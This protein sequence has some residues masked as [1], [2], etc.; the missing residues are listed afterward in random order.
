MWSVRRERTRCG[1]PRGTWRRSCPGSC[2]CTGVGGLVCWFPAATPAP[3]TAGYRVWIHSI[4]NTVFCWFKVKYWRFGLVGRANPMHRWVADPRNKA[5]SVS[6]YILIYAMLVISPLLKW[7]PRS[8]SGWLHGPE[9]CTSLPRSS[10]WSGGSGQWSDLAAARH[11]GNGYAMQYNTQIKKG[12]WNNDTWDEPQRTLVLMFSVPERVSVWAASRSGSMEGRGWSRHSFYT[13]LWSACL[14]GH[15]GKHSTSFSRGILQRL[16][17]Y[18]PITCIKNEEEVT[19]PTFRPLL[20][21][22]R[23][24]DLL[25]CRQTGQSRGLPKAKKNIMRSLCLN[26]AALR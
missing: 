19:S 21:S 25:T 1:W 11:R 10:G 18:L 6:C 14:G 7:G 20:C 4:V 24:S 2:A 26:R 13:L 22:R 15:C 8:Q 12:N 17:Q 23:I 3:V 5:N 16:R 9:T